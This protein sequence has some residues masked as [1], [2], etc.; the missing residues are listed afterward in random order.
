[1]VM[2]FSFKSYQNIFT[3]I[4]KILKLNLLRKDQKK[5][6]TYLHKITKL[7]KYLTGKQNT[8]T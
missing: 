1:M 8:K 7:K 2:E 5:F 3:N 6:Q 4:K